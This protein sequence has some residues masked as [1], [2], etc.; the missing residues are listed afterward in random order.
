ML[1]KPFACYATGVLT[2]ALAVSMGCGHWGVISYAMGVISV[3][4]GLA[5]VLSRKWGARCALAILR[6]IVGEPEPRAARSGASPSGPK[7]RSSS[8]LDEAEKSLGCSRR[9]MPWSTK[10]GAA[11][12]RRELR[13]GDPAV[14]GI[15]RLAVVGR[16]GGDL[17]NAIQNL[18]R[19]VAV[20]RLRWLLV[21]EH[22]PAATA[23]RHS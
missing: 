2:T 17:P 18:C 5:F 15:A 23:P 7:A 14:F 22:P 3:L 6:R 12:A 4:V 20:D 21:R 9:F 1:L 8:G 13:K 16:L 11:K 10:G 19:I